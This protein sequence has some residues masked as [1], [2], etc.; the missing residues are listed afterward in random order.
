MIILR[1]AASIVAR[2]FLAALLVAGSFGPG[3]VTA[4][5]LIGLESRHVTGQVL[6]GTPDHGCC[7]PGPST[8][9]RTCALAC[10]QAACGALVIAVLAAWPAMAGMGERWLLPA[11]DMPAGIAVDP[12]TPPPRA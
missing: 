9:D 12:A 4:G 3:P 1:S 11:T 5:G 8:G 2:L 6:T 10:A 7:D